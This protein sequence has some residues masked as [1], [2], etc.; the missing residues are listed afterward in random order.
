MTFEDFVKTIPKPQD[1][2][3]YN[4]SALRKVWDCQQQ[5]IDELEQW[6]AAIADDHVATPD[7]IRHSARCLL[8][9]E[10]ER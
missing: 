7:W 4:K 6:I 2:A 9:Q 3:L 10:Q 5:R 8:A 1:Y